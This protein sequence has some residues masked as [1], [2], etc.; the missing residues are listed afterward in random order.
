M[1]RKSIKL[2]RN[3]CL[4]IPHNERPYTETQAAAEFGVSPRTLE[5]W[6]LQRRLPAGIVWFRVGLGKRQVV[7]YIP[8]TVRRARDEC[9]RAQ[10]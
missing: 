1:S 6:R 10:F 5:T 3:P 8:S 4:E 9:I 2:V 7:R